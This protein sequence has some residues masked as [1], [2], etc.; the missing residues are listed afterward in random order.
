MLALLL[1]A[2]PTAADES[3]RNAMADAMARMMEAMG[4]GGDS[5]SDSPMDPRGFGMP[6][7][8][9][10]GMSPWS[11][12]Q[13]GMDAFGGNPFL[14]QPWSRMMPGTAAGT[15]MEQMMRQMPEIPGLPGWQRTRLEGIWE[16]RD[17]GLLIVQSP[18]FRLY[19]PRGGYIEGLI[20]QRGDR[21]ALYDSRH[22]TARPY[23]FAE[24]QGRLVLRDAD[25]QVFLYRRLWLDDTTG[26]GYSGGDRR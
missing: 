19:S 23:E 4:F 13:Y 24:S 11:L 14:Q 6:G 3:S 1:L 8:G 25:G 20:Q 16:G 18:R 15:G 21:V 26:I 10:M 2:L 12:G 7:M 17:G 22:E 5:K 9:G